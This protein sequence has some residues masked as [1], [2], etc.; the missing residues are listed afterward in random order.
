MELF[1][2]CC[3][4]SQ[5]QASVSQGRICLTS[6][7]QASVSQGRICLTSQQ[8][9]SV[10]QGRI[11]L[12]SQQQA[13]VSQGRICLTSQQQANVSQ[14][15]ICLD[16]CTCCHTE[17]K[18][19]DQNFYINQSRYTDTESTSPNADPLRQAP[20]RTATGVSFFFTCCSDSTRRNPKAQAGLE[21]RVFRSG[22]R[23]LN[24]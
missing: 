1:L 2:D 5:Q 14:G 18:V 13:S 19:A 7:Q 3:L 22:S 10:S 8:Q 15:R 20:G 9:A 4:T 16:N 24:H 21:P 12:T 6:Q 23:R 17:I 11:C